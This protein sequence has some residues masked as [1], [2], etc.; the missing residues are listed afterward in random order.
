MQIKPFNYNRFSA[1]FISFIAR[2]LKVILRF[3]TLVKGEHK[4]L[5]VT[6]ERKEIDYCKVNNFFASYDNKEAV[7]DWLYD[8]CPQS[9]QR[10]YF[11]C[12]DSL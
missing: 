6:Q 9:V 1:C 11:L 8:T 5:R 2:I 12:S 4:N 7:Q 10:K 3:D